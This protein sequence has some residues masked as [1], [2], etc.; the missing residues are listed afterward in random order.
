[1]EQLLSVLAVQGFWSYEARFIL[2]PA[3]R[4]REPA[5]DTQDRTRQPR[6]SGLA[7]MGEWYIISAVLVHPSGA[8][9]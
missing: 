9:K 6:S 4:G 1:M 7:F 3:R 8:R 2:V 5:L